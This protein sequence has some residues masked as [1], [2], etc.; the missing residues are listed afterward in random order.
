MEELQQ[1]TGGG[2][3]RQMIQRVT[4]QYKETGLTSQDPMQEIKDLVD[5]FCGEQ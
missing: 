5:L 4:Q 3:A 1:T 2:Y